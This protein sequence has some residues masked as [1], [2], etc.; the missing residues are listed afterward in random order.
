MLPEMND[1]ASVA[2][3]QSLIVGE[4][5]VEVDTGHGL[6]AGLDGAVGAVLVGTADSDLEWRNVTSSSRNHW[7]SG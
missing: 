6:A 1:D 4:R 7:V 5:D 3:I 2:A